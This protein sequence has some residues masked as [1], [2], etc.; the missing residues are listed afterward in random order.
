MDDNTAQPGLMWSFQEKKVSRDKN[1]KSLRKAK[2]F[3]H[4]EKL[5]LITKAIRKTHCCD[6]TIGLGVVEGASL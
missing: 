2:T 1:N 4:Y 5:H 6:K 3:K